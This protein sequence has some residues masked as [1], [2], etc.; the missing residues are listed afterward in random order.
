M[1]NIKNCR[2]CG[3]IFNYVAGAVLCQ[4]CREEM[5]KKFQEVKEY[6][7]SNPGVGAAEVSEAC[8]VEASQIRAWLREERLELAEGSSILLSCESCGAQIRS[9]RYCDK[10]KYEL[11]MGLKSAMRQNSEDESRKKGA[12]TGREAGS[13]RMRFL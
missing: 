5:E 11:T 10:C 7:R 3:R 2:R 6:I 8:H 1:N 9:G 4:P 12:D 13:S